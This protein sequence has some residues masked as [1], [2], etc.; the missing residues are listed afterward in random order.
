[1]AR[2][3]GSMFVHATG[4]QVVEDEHLAAV[5][6]QAFAEMRADEAGASS[7]Q[8]APRPGSQ[9]HRCS[10]TFFSGESLESM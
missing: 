9:R 10:L 2:A 5:L 1:M 6:E 8:H 3:D 7:D 4:E